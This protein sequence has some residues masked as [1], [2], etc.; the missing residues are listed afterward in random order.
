MNPSQ[1]TIRSITHSDIVT[2]LH[3]KHSEDVAVSECNTGSSTQDPDCKRID[4][5]AMKKSWAHPTIYAYEIKTSRSDFLSD[6][7]WMGYLKYCTDF[8]FIAPPDIIQVEEL[9]QEV[10]LMVCSKN[11]KRLYTKRKAAHRQYADIDIPDRI[12]RYILFSR[13]TIDIQGEESRGSGVEYYRKMLASKDAR[14][15]VGYIMAYKIRKM[16]DAKIKD[17]IVENGNLRR[18][19]LTYKSFKE[20]L[21]GLGL[22]GDKLGEY[23]TI[24]QLQR[25]LSRSVDAIITT[26][27]KINLSI[28]ALGLA[29]AALQIEIDDPTG[30]RR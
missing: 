26:K 30:E 8:Y 19:V 6:N 15:D 29:A 24:A 11:A 28:K 7:K 17:V 18:E 14:K 20:W 21:I 25:K 3:T 9:P 23:Q 12:Y 5:W 4:F 27:N 2:L 1:H 13:A 22:D 16:A 10:G